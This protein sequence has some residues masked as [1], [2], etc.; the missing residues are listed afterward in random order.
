M[1]RVIDTPEPPRDIILSD[2][3]HSKVKELSNNV[4]NAL[5]TKQLTTSHIFGG[6]LNEMII[7][8]EH[9]IEDTGHFFTPEEMAKHQAV[10]DTLIDLMVMLNDLEWI[11]DQNA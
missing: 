6:I 1:D 8:K 9:Y 11:G 4:I 10:L 2:K 3:V 7:D 5:R